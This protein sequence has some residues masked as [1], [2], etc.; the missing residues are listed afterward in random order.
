MLSYFVPAETVPLMAVHALFALCLV[1]A[2]LA[3]HTLTAVLL[4]RNSIIGA[5]SVLVSGL[6]IL[7]GLWGLTLDR[8][9]ALGT[10]AEFMR[11]QTTPLPESNIAGVMNIVGIIQGLTAG[12]LLLWLYTGGKKLRAR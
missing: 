8:Y 6:L 11:G 7:V 9:M 5:V 10:F 4:Q 2:A 12:V 3:G 1:I